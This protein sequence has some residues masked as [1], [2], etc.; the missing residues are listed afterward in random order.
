MT[1][2]RS[3]ARLRSPTIQTIVLSRWILALAIMGVGLVALPAASH[4]RGAT[5]PI[6]HVR[7]TP[8]IDSI[9]PPGAE[10]AHPA[11]A[12]SRAQ[13]PLPTLSGAKFRLGFL[14]FKDDADAP[15]R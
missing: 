6:E 15:P 4:V 8:I 2:W 11:A 12:P 10:G 1:I 5:A 13:P 7:T 14:E 3:A 9:V